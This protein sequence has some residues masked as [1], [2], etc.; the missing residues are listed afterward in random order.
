MQNAQA[1]FTKWLNGYATEIL[2]IANKY[3]GTET[4]MR[5]DVIRNI[6]ARRESFKAVF[7][8]YPK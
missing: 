2:Q 8:Q 4:A 5:S 7:G 6:A 3:P 1:E